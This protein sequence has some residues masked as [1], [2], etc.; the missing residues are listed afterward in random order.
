MK[1]SCIVKIYFAKFSQIF[2]KVILDIWSYEGFAKRKTFM[3]QRIKEIK[4]IAR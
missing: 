2:G 1:Q 4:K 3:Q